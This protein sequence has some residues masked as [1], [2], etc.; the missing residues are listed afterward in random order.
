MR[1]KARHAVMRAYKA[2]KD[3]SKSTTPFCSN[4]NVLP[5]LLRIKTSNRLYI[6]TLTSRKLYKVNVSHSIIVM[7]S[8]SSV[9]QCNSSHALTVGD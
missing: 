8:L 5:E 2:T 9:D 1:N 7:G 3:S 6:E 4:S